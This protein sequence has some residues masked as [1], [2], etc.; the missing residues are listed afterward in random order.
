MV[1]L[2]NLVSDRNHI[3]SLFVYRSW[4][5]V[6]EFTFAEGTLSKRA[7]CRRGS[8]FPGLF[9][10]LWVVCVVTNLEHWSHQT[11]RRLRRLSSLVRLIARSPWG[12]ACSAL[13]LKAAR[14][15]SF[16]IISM[17]RSFRD[18]RILLRVPKDG[19]RPMI[20]IRTTS[21]WGS[22]SLTSL[23]LLQM[24]SVDLT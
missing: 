3:P 14:R 21:L 5:N 7:L 19:G 15:R 2:K 23:S 11:F 12:W 22:F 17:E 1:P 9:Q 4:E 13:S 8:G 24:A 20:V 18:S 16:F 6:S 10:Q